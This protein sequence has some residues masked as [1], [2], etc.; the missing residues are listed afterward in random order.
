M[1]KQKPKQDTV[2]QIT[3]IGRSLKKQIK[4]AKDRKEWGTLFQLLKDPNHARFWEHVNKLR[5]G[6]KSRE[7]GVSETDGVSNV[8][9]L[10]TTSYQNQTWPATCWT[11]FSD[12]S[13]P[14]LH[15]DGTPQRLKNTKRAK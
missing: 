11:R 8:T 7:N 10:H 15:S 6:H 9:L 5:N 2:A 4:E 13:T 1:H 14:L 3:K 12:H